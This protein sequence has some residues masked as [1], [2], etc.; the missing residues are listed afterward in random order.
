M[1]P[2]KHPW[3]SSIG[4]GQISFSAAGPGSGPPP[5]SMYYT[6]LS[7]GCVT[8]QLHKRSAI[9]LD[10]PVYI[11]AIFVFGLSVQHERTVYSTTPFVLRKYTYTYVRRALLPP[12]TA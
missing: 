7:Q 8:Q 1:F 6:A 5:T 10:C 11:F 2:S 9:F 12:L 4:N 3:E